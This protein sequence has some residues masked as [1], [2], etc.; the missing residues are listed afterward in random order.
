[1]SSTWVVGDIHG[2]A[3]ELACLLEELDLQDGDRLISTGDLFHRGPHPV[4]VMRLLQGLGN[5]FEMVLGNH[6]WA[7]LRSFGREPRKADGSGVPT[8][9][10]VIVEGIKDLRG[11][12][13]VEMDPSAL[14]AGVEMLEFLAG[15]AYFLRGPCAGPAWREEAR[16]WLIVHGS[17]LPD[18]AV[19]EMAPGELVHLSRCQDRPGSPLWH[20]V[21]QGPEFVVFGHAQSAAGDHRASDG[22]LLSWGL[23][24][25]CVYGGSLS[26]LR[27][28]DLATVD[29]PAGG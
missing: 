3:V 18:R 8:T 6:E 22:S 24:R 19:E 4:E 10:E 1:M 26:A 28:E 14:S 27:L 7:L 29:I 5:R 16:D 21:W 12:N 15:R 9:G 11:D 20:E 13:R 23:D 2:C 17:V 25:G